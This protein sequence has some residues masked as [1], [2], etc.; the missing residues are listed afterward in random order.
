MI[1]TLSMM[2]SGTLVTPAT[3]TAIESGI[4]EAASTFFIKEEYRNFQQA[5]TELKLKML[6]R[7][8]N[9]SIKIKLDNKDVNAEL[10]RLLETVYAEDSLNS[11]AGDYLRHSIL[12]MQVSYQTMQTQ[13]SSTL[14][15]TFTFSCVYSSTLPQE[16]Y[17]TLQVKKIISDMKLAGRPD[18]EKIKAVYDYVTKRVDYDYNGINNASSHSAYAALSEKKAVCQGYSALI[19]RLMRECGIQNRII[20]GKSQNQEHAW[21]IVQL[22][23][24]WYNL[25]ATWDSNFDGNDQKYM[26]FL[27]GTSEFTDHTRDKE[28]Q[29]AEFLAKYPVSTASY[30]K[31]Q[32]AVTKVTGVK[33]ANVT[34]S[35]VT[36][37]WNAQKNAE[38]Y[39]VCHLVNGKYQTSSKWKAT[40]NSLKISTDFNGSRLKA[41]QKYTYGVIAYNKKTG[42]TVLSDPVTVTLKK[43]VNPS[44]TAF[45]KLTTSNGKITAA[46]KKVSSC[47]GYQLQYSTDKKFSSK[48]TV[49]VKTSGENAVQS[50]VKS[51]KK[52]KTYYFRIRAWKKSEGEILY[53]PWSSIKGIKCK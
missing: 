16:A 52:G 43:T 28:F 20:T 13:E 5:A 3:V 45:T 34:D 25:D 35:S 41:G 42:N 44:K 46:W 4:T 27:K 12:Q 49:T 50:T 23:G 36:L 48:A 33:A 40:T 47:G 39:Y 29:T 9:I 22:N 19:Y 32:P 14:Y 30:A 51:L 38:C 8:Q 10:N 7:Q 11:A 6:G 15:C 18:D 26:Y 17:V 2:I 37:T 53:A 1:L 21:N 24:K 31:Y